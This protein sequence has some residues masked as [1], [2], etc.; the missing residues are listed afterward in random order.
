MPFCEKE[1]NVLVA[2]RDQDKLKAFAAF[3]ES[4]S[5]QTLGWDEKERGISKAGMIVNATPLGMGRG[6]AGNGDVDL[7]FSAA[8]KPAI[9]YDL[10][11][12]PSET[13]FLRHAKAAGLETIGGLG[14]LVHQAVPTFEAWFGE[15][16]PVDERLYAILARELKTIDDREISRSYSALRRAEKRP[17]RVAAMHELEADG[18]VKVVRH[19]RDG[20]PYEWK[21]NPRVHDGRFRQ[22]ALLENDRRTAV[23]EKIAAEAERLRIQKE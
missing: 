13:G 9:A 22:R 5:I 14:M 2:G 12:A 11:Y 7:S 18:W 23:R 20:R 17:Q 19:H 3:F 15:Q 10:I 8:P 21:I 6:M 4:K 1:K 16:P